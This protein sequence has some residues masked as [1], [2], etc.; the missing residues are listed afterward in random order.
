M[1]IERNIIFKFMIGF[2]IKNN[3]SNDIWCICVRDG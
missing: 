1:T 2:L 3:T